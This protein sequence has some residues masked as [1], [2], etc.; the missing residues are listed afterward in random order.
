MLQEMYK[1]TTSPANALSTTRACSDLISS[2]L[3][4]RD[5]NNEL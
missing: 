4:Y 1:T 5:W 3:D 2:L